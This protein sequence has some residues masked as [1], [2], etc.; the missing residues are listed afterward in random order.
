MGG[1][2]FRPLSTYLI[3]SAI[4][5]LSRSIAVGGLEATS[6]ESCELDFESYVAQIRSNVKPES[7]DNF[8]QSPVGKTHCMGMDEAFLL[9]KGKL[10]P[11][12]YDV[13][14]KTTDGELLLEYFEA[15]K[16]LTMAYA[17]LERAVAHDRLVAQTGETVG[18]F[19]QA[20]AP[21]IEVSQEPSQM[22]VQAS[23][24]VN[25]IDNRI[26]ALFKIIQNHGLV[27]TQEELARAGLGAPAFP[28]DH[29]YFRTQP[30]RDYTYGEYLEKR[31][32]K[33]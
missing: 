33:S 2:M 17:K 32:P 18:K 4:A 21:A 28:S 19:T 31:L 13:K 9:E 29:R 1:F 11:A 15:R 3:A 24:D 22:R 12:L 8:L 27:K 14:S 20:Q 5:L 23:K 7:I 10:A 25:M 26:K 16:F 30:D 6:P